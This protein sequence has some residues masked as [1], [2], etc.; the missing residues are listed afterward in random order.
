MKVLQINSVCGIGST[1]RI[2]IDIH[3]LLIEH[4]HESYIAYGRNLPK[5][6]DIAI[7]IGTKFDNYAH[8]A[9]TRMFDMHGFG[10]KKA[11]TEFIEKVKE[12]DP[13]IIHLHNIHGYYIN[14]EILFNY[15]KK[16]NKPVIWTLHDCW[17]FT[18]HC[19]YFDY[20]DCDK[21]K[22]GCYDCP[23]KKSYPSSRLLDNSK[24]NYLRKKEIFNGINCMT[25]VTPSMWLAKLVKESFLG[26]YPIKIINNGID[27]NVI[28]PT[29]SNFRERY[30]LEAKFIILGV[31]NIWDRRKGFE[32]F[33]EL[34]Q[35]LVFDEVIIMVGLTK[36]QKKELPN[37][38]IG[39]TRTNNVKELAEIY[40]AAD[41]F[42]NTTLEDNFPTTNLEALACGTPVITFQT[43]GS[44]ESID[45]NTGFVVGKNNINELLSKIRKIKVMGKTCYSEN[46]ITRANK[47][48]NKED[49]FSEYINLYKENSR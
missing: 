31:A 24:S 1:G 22:T 47:L 23:E 30:N 17:T 44:V 28:K 40:T 21:W 48:Y 35:K 39:I 3:N 16:V 41:V 9:K 19:S 43:G 13:D 2:A 20:A 10:S 49:R 12:L 36:K 32:H 45:E 4:G 26:E 34:S 29:E 27:L 11:T 25:I 33:I 38:I 37:N 7:K 6:C 5:N 15:L 14:T 8:V 18:G 46:T 42:V